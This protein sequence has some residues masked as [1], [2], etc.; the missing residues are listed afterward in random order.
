M[1]RQATSKEAILAQCRELVSQGGPQAL[2]IREIAR[3][4]GVA[5]GCLY[6]YFPSKGALLAA[7]TESVWADIFAPVRGQSAGFP[8]FVRSLFESAAAN[9]RR[10]P[11][12]FAAHSESFG[13]GDI[14]GAR[15]AMDESMGRVRSALLAALDAD[16]GVSPAAFGDELTREGFADFCLTALVGLLFRGADSCGE[17]TVLIGRAIY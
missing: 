12:F 14:G 6:N 9:A 7:V 3:R 2:N 4:C 11:G 1:N 13:P 15:R 10:Y 16:P 8:E 5:P 17:L